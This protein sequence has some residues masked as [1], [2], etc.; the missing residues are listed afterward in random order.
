M[1]KMVIIGGGGHAKVLISIIKKNK[2][3]AIAGYVD[4]VDR[5]DILG[6]PYLGDDTRLKKIWDDGIRN[7]SLGV[8][9]PNLEMKRQEISNKVESMGFYFPPII[10]GT[11]VIN[12]GVMIG[13]GSQVFDGV[14]I[15]SGASIGRFCV[16][17]T[18]TTIEHDCIISDFCHLAPGVVLSGVVE[19]GPFSM[20]G[21]GAVV[22]PSIK[23]AGHC[24]I[25]AGAVVAHDCT[26]P[27]TYSGIPAR[28]IK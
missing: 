3:F 14:V 28:K 27:G 18:H 6:I 19:L 11:A 9:H 5:N 1:E 15:N 21:T 16:I 2:H 17:N 22:N 10:S 13:E 20:V 24:M 7:A 23:I 8:G 26:E 25:G 12:E 4:N